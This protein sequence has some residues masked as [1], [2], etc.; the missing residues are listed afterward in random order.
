MDFGAFL[1]GVLAGGA[2]LVTAGGGYLV[3][4]VWDHWD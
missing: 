3:A 2:M 4:A 1:I